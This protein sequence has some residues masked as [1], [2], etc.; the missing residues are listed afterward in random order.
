MAAPAEK[1]PHPAQPGLK[2]V[3]RAEEATAYPSPARVLQERLQSSQ[4]SSPGAA[5]IEDKRWPLYLAL[6]FWL[7]LSGLT[8][9]AII[10]GVLALI[11][12][13]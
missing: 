11:P 4:L 9:A 1:R 6:P 13:H 5:A 3:E 2:A 10:A 8:W 7:G 12:H